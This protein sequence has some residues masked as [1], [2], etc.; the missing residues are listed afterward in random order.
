MLVH[1]KKPEKWCE[2]IKAAKREPIKV[3]MAR[4]LEIMKPKI[5]DNDI[6]LTDKNVRMLIK[7]PMT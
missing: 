5:E 3:S 4:A 1:K 6:E 7:C 2:E